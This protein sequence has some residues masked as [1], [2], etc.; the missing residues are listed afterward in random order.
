MVS[1]ARRIARICFCWIRARVSMTHTHAHPGSDSATRNSA[2][3]ENTACGK[4]CSDNKNFPFVP[5]RLECRAKATC[6]MLRYL[7]AFSGGRLRKVF[8]CVESV[9][10]WPAV[11]THPIYGQPNERNTSIRCAGESGV[12]VATMKVRVCMTHGFMI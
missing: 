9:W 11:I 4:L 8:R 12:S 5:R 3:V 10:L 1:I 7:Q 2:L 6:S